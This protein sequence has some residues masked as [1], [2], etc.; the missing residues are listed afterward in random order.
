MPLSMGSI[1]ILAVLFLTVVPEFSQEPE[2]YIQ[3]GHSL[4]VYSVTFSPDGKTIATGSKDCTIRLWDVASGQELR[5]FGSSSL[6]VFARGASS[7]SSVAFSP[8]GTKLAGSDGSVAFSPD[9]MTLASGGFHVPRLWDVASGGELK[10]LSRRTPVA[11]GPEPIQAITLWDV[12]TGQELD[13]LKGHSN[14]IV[15]VAFSP[16]G[17]TLVS[18]SW[19]HTIKLWYVASGKELKTFNGHSR[20]VYSVAFSPDGKKVASGSLDS[21]VKLWD[22][23]SGQ[24]LKS[25]KKQNPIGSNP[26]ITYNPG[27]DPVFS[28]AFSPDGQTVAS[29]NSDNTIKLW[30]VTSGQ[31]LKALKGH[32]HFVQSVAFSPNGKMLA[33]GSDDRTIK[34]WDVASGQELRTLKGHSSHV[35][36]V[37]LIVGGTTLES[38]GG[39]GIMLWDVATGQDVAFSP[40]GKTRA[41]GSGATIKLWDVASAKEL[42]TLKGHSNSVESVA[43]SSD[44]KTLASGGDDDTIKLWNVA[45]GQEVKSLKGRTN[46]MTVHAVAFSPNG[47]TLASSNFGGIKLWDVASGQELMTLTGSSSAR[48]IAFSADGKTLAGSGK[49]WDVASGQELIK[50]NRQWMPGIGSD[51]QVYSVAF[52]PDGKT[53]ATGSEANFKLWDVATGRELKTLEGRSQTKIT[54]STDGKTLITGSLDRTVIL[55]DVESGKR[56]ASLIALDEKDWAI[57]TPEG[58]FDGSPNAWKQLV[59]RL[60]N[61]TFKYAPVEA[62]FKEFY[63]PGLLQEIVEGKRPRPAIKNLSEVDIRQPGVNITRVG[64]EAV[65]DKGLGQPVTLSKA[66]LTRNVEVEIQLTDNAGQPLRPNHPPTSGAQDLRLFRNGSLVKLWRGSLFDKQSG[67]EQTAGEPREARRAICRVTIP[68]VAGDNDLTAY[69]FNHENVKSNDGEA[70]VKGSESLRRS[71]TLYTLAIGVNEYANSQ[72]NL[73]YAVADAQDFAAELK[74]QQ[75]ALGNYERE[76][77]ICLADKDATKANILTS[78]ADLSAKIQ[79]EDA[80]VIYFAGHGTAQQNRFYMIPHDLGYAGSRTQLNAASL[81]NILAHSISDEELERAVEG[82][83]AGQ[84]ALV[85]D[86]CNS[87][88]ALESEEKRRGPMNSKGLAQLAYEKGMYILTAAQ[89]Y[90]A[91]QEATKLGHGFLTYSLVDEGLKTGAADTDKDGQVLLREWL[92]YAVGRVPQMQLDDLKTRQLEREKSNGADPANGGNLQ[93]PRV[94]YRREAETHPLVVAKP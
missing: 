80:L 1:L 10:T 87:G 57:A 30:D 21:T 35:R 9:G 92:D 3:T 26:I 59:W 46:Y 25:L 23:D 78:L 61:N 42:K 94:F 71:G 20:D 40:D 11:L 29:G 43:F 85:I 79:P 53:L 55:W 7:V 58:L 50:L 39:I 62:F 38:S 51:G 91:A 16:D 64:G 18:G 81:Q 93:R 84:M 32:S 37:A 66:V 54:F 41:N 68:I 12:A 77:I 75:A 24:E 63:Y 67:C 45:S 14:S 2:L 28:V 86:A 88:Q 49:L 76:E 89:S 74:R 13:T 73:R 70:L 36:S 69:A 17:K 44:G 52:S 83:D 72:Y 56:L 8:D 31:E 65:Q 4:E 22:I 60:D 48:S 6:D 15:S 82:I 34:L 47:K 19:D 90:Q 27:Y 33:S 5:T